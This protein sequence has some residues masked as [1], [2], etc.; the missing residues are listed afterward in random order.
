MELK[1]MPMGENFKIDES[2][3][4]EFLLNLLVSS[5]KIENFNDISV[6]IVTELHKRFADLTA[7]I[8]AVEEKVK[9]LPE[10]YVSETIK[11]MFA[12]KDKTVKEFVFDLVN[13]ET[14]ALQS[15]IVI[16]PNNC[17]ACGAPM[18]SV[19]DYQHTTSDLYREAMREVRKEERLSQLVIKS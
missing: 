14:T 5:L 19:V 18:V 13:P 17:P 9:L 8:A 7:F 1:E 4:S 16:N 6:S 3:S 12:D 2:H 15:N 10:D 11:N